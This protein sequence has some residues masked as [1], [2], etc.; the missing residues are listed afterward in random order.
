MVPKKIGDFLEYREV[1]G[2]TQKSYWA[3]WAIVEE[4]R[5]AMGGGA[6]FLLLGPA[7]RERV[8]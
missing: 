3:Y 4:T 8:R 5:Q 2:T 1:I 7:A 6:P